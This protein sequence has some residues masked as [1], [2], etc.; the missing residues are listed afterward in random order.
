MFNLTIKF[1]SGFTFLTI[2]CG[3]QAFRGTTQRWNSPGSNRISPG[4]RM[5]RDESRGGLD[6]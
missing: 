6:S 5:D 1:S 2:V 3:E 4:K